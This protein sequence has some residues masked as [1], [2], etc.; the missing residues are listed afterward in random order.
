[1][2]NPNPFHPQISLLDQKNKKRARVKVAVYSIFAFNVLL[3]SPLLIQGCRDKQPASQTADNT[4]TAPTN[5][6]TSTAPSAETPSNTAAPAL[7]SPPSNVVSA[8]PMNPTANPVPAVVSAA[9][10]DYVIVKGDTF[11]KIAHA[12]GLTVKALVDANPGLD[13][14]RLQIGKKLQIPPPSTAAT[15]GPTTAMMADSA[16]TYVVK[17]GDSLSKIAH[18]HNTTVKALRA[19][20]DLKTNKIIVGQ[21]LKLPSPSA[22]PA[23]ATADTTP[24][25]PPTTSTVS[26]ATPP[27][28]AGG[29][30]H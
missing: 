22:A 2:N 15:S 30:A 11:S 26:T 25:S 6:T 3:I 9:N 8:P 28:A 17:S 27:P 21:K 13:P 24:V 14:A 12:H 29:T 1:M 23:A 10:T 5:D 4:T 20:N 16:D 19:A 7:P 18:E